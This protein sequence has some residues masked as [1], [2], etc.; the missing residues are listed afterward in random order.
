VQHF[1]Q[2][3]FHALNSISSITRWCFIPMVIGMYYH[4]FPPESEE[5]K[6]ACTCEWG[7][8]PSMQAA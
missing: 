8:K 6:V 4:V 2:L 3:V 5:G 7:H 1:G